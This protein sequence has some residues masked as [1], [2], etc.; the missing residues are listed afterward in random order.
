MESEFNK[1]FLDNTEETWNG[2][3]FKDCDAFERKGDEV[4]YMSE[5]QLEKLS[6]ADYEL[7]DTEI[8]E[9]DYGESYNSILSLCKARIDEVRESMLWHGEDEDFVKK[10][11]AEDLAQDIFEWADWASISTYIEERTQ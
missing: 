3:I 1:R 2:L 10:F 5:Y 9:G 6:E 4:C 7:T 8:I 11:T